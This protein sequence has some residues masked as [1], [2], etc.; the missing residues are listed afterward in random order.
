MPIGVCTAVDI[1]TEMTRVATRPSLA[2]KQAMTVQE[3][4]TAMLLGGF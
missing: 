2:T 3:T 4:T 1:V